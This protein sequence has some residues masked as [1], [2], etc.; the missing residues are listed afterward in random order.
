VVARPLDWLGNDVDEEGVSHDRQGRPIDPARYLTVEGRLVEDDARDAAYTRLL[1]SS[2]VSAFRKNSV[3]LPT[4]LV[5]FVFLERLRR[6]RREP[7]LF[8]FMRSL[9]P[10]RSIAVSD[11]MSDLS[12]ASNELSVLER[13]GLIRLDAALRGAD[14]ERILEEALATFATYHVVPV[15]RRRGQRIF[16]GDPGLLLYYQNRLDGYGLL[17]RE[18]S[19]AVSDRRLS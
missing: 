10:E 18:A 14:E 2:I 12:R 16:V 7:S 9:G 4:S 1:S 13:K 3:A 5:A 17:Q 8:R 19:P 11:L 15:L 6:E